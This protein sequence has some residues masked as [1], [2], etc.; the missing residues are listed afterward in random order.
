MVRRK[1]KKSDGSRSRR[2]SG[3]P[4]ARAKSPSTRAGKPRVRRK[5]RRSRNS[6][7][8]ITALAAAAAF[9]VGIVAMQYTKDDI[10]GLI[11]GFHT[12]LAPAETQ[13]EVRYRDVDL[14][15]IDPRTVL[16]MPIKARV[17]LSKTSTIE[18]ELSQVL[19]ALI[20]G[21]QGVDPSESAGAL[22]G[23]R[24]TLPEGTRLE[25]LSVKG[26]TAY[27]DLSRELLTNHSG[28]STDE[29]HTVYSIVNTL[30]LNYSEIDFVQILIGGRVEETI[31]GH[32]ILDA[33]L[34]PDIGL[35][36]S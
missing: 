22:G 23:V 31:G 16:L 21:P 9:V 29:L 2:K 13:V 26:R 24:A 32:I 7:S 27:V 35:V 20:K 33:P 8:W 17:K 34:G 12:N 36:K 18:D 1:V 30:T 3:T 10:S 11:S 5:K 14:Y 25:G 15:F 28:G 6:L 19:R 4:A